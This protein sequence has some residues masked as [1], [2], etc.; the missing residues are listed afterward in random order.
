MCRI[1]AYA[2]PP[3]A[4][5]ALLSAPPHS[6]EHQAGAP[7][8]QDP[9]RINADG[10]GVAWYDHA[11]G[12]VADICAAIS[13]PAPVTGADGTRYVV[14]REWSNQSGACIVSK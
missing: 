5:D 10:W 4:L 13:T 9:G 2:G 1:L 11:N 8:L 3:V 7:R 14:Q 6:L 12:E